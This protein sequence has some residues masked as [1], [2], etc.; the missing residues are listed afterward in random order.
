MGCWKAR[1]V[2]LVS[3]QGSRLCADRALG[4]TPEPSR[5]RL[6]RQG[7]SGDRS[8]R[9]TSNTRETT[10]L[11]DAARAFLRCH[12][13]VPRL[14]RSLDSARPRHRGL[15]RLRTPRSC[16]STDSASALVDL[17]LVWLGVLFD[18]SMGLALGLRLRL[19]HRR[20]SPC[21]ESRQRFG[22]RLAGGSLATRALH[23][24]R[25]RPAVGTSTP[26]RRRRASRN[27]R[28]AV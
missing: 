9:R 3:R 4:P 12:D 10:R 26:P 11:G 2:I 24:S 17:R 5:V 27:G 28:E 18:A 13:R 6:R 16:G 22:G 14:P 7:V 23:A 8:D 19:L 15:V 25:D 21:M 20:Q 1:G